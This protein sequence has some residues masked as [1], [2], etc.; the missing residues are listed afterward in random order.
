MKTQDYDFREG[1]KEDY[2]VYIRERKQWVEVNKEVYNYL[3]RAIWREEKA[4]YR[5]SE[6]CASLDFQY[7]FDTGSVNAVSILEKNYP[8]LTSPS[9][10]DVFLQKESLL[11]LTKNIENVCSPS[12]LYLLESLVMNKV[13]EQAY[14]DRLGVARS[15]IHSRKMA[16]LKKIK[17]YLP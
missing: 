11:E 3:K 1:N 14:A 17:K 7:N 2:Y 12:E 16:V 13:T 6:R 9:A 8:E 4:D 15:T 5:K 10:E